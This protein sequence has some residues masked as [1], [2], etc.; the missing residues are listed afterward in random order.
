MAKPADPNDTRQFAH[1]E[2][3]RSLKEYTKTH[4]A[5]SNDCDWLHRLASSDAISAGKIIPRYL[6]RVCYK[7]T[8]AASTTTTKDFGT[9]P[10]ELLDLR[11]CLD[12]KHVRAVTL[13]HRDSSQVDPEILDLLWC[14]FK[15]GVS[16]MRHHFDYKEFRDEPGC[17]EFIRNRLKEESQEKEDYWTFGGR[18]NPVRLPSETR[19]SILRLSIDSERL[20]VSCRGGISKSS[21]YQMS[22]EVTGVIAEIVI[23]LVRSKAVYQAPLSLRDRYAGRERHS[24]PCAIDLFAATTDMSSISHELPSDSSELSYRIV[25]FYARLLVLRCYEDYHLRHDPEPIHLDESDRIASQGH[26]HILAIHYRRLELVKFKHDLFGHLGPLAPEQESSGSANDQY[27]RRL[28]SLLT[29]VEM[30][31][32]L[33]DNAVRIYEWHI[34]E[35]NSDYT[36]ELASEQLEEARQSKATAISLGKLS[37]LAF[38]YLPLNFVCAMLGMNL[39]IYGQGKVPVWVFLILVVLFSLLTY[40]PI[41]PPPID[42][43]RFRFYKVAYLLAWRSVPAGFWFLAFYL[44]HDYGQNFEIM[45]SG[46]AQVFLGHTGRKTKGWTDGRQDRLFAKA[47][48]GS[49][50]FWKGKTKVIFLAVKELNPNDE[51]TQ[52]TV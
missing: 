21:L 22:S 11:H 14:K 6:V 5:R 43:R 16:F 47:A 39:S 10:S 37:N 25:H 1:A 9:G 18:W 20:S 41:Y 30:L 40:T 34:H 26:P 45:N 38:I 8:Q 32:S 3:S 33:Y 42:R 46:L 7:N 24:H 50:A 35:I 2:D 17:P 31:L 44:T 4:S 15:L 49:E 28:Q 36:G 52:L 12:S 27:Q 51:D 23:A 29:D 48:W 19:A 13:C